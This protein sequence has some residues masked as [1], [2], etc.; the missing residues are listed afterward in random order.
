MCPRWLRCA[1]TNDTV[2]IMVHTHTHHTFPN[3]RSYYSKMRPGEHADASIHRRRCSIQNEARSSF[4]DSDA[5]GGVPNE[6]F[7]AFT[8]Y[9]CALCKQ[10]HVCVWVSLTLIPSQKLHCIHW[11]SVINHT[12]FVMSDKEAA[13]K[14][15]WERM[16]ARTQTHARTL[17][18]SPGSGKCHRRDAA[19]MRIVNTTHSNE[20]P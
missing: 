8:V 11:I 5:V 10:A 19:Y 7:D 20:N 18:P 6:R 3:S 9:E 13:A 15:Q 17:R 14:M 2:V 12:Q 16:E 4:M 1:R